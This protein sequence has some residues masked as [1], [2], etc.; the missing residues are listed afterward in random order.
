M[1]RYVKSHTRII[2]HGDKKYYY[3]TDPLIDYLLKDVNALIKKR[4]S[5]LK[6]ERKSIQGSDV[7]RA[8]ERTKNVYKDI[9]SWELDEDAMKYYQFLVEPF[10][11]PYDKNKAYKDQY[12]CTEYQAIHLATLICTI[13]FFPK[14]SYSFGKYRLFFSSFEDHL[15]SITDIAKKT[16]DVAYE[17]YKKKVNRREQN[18]ETAEDAIDEDQ[19]GI[20]DDLNYGNYFNRE[21]I[22]LLLKE[23]FYRQSGYRVKEWFIALESRIYALLEKIKIKNDDYQSFVLEPLRDA[24]IESLKRLKY[25]KKGVDLY[26]YE[27]YSIKIKKNI[28]PD[29]TD[30]DKIIATSK[31]PKNILVSGKISRSRVHRCRLLCGKIPLRR[32]AQEMLS[33]NLSVCEYHK[34]EVSDELW[35]LL[36]PMMLGN[37]GQRGRKGKNNRQFIN[38]VFWIMRND[39]PWRNLPPEYG[40]WN[41]VH[42]RFLRWRKEG[43]WIKILEILINVPECD[44]LFINPTK[45]PSRAASGDGNPIYLMPWMEMTGLSKCLKHKINQLITVLISSP[46]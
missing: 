26:D 5:E 44:W 4:I 40:N 7:H 20:D 41:S 24:L 29:N 27:D 22:N 34:Q 18:V 42:K 21:E 14:E 43:V 32:R 9:A 36:S 3:E 38:A 6:P 15:F 33:E 28:F 13:Y 30:V 35:E 1:A 23:T 39:E 2:E 11:Y 45:A 12:K 16:R 19:S 46:Y 25:A 8:I 37:E 31:S 10:S 17:S